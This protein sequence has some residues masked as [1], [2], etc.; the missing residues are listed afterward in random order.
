MNHKIVE[1]ELQEGEIIEITPDMIV[2]DVL[3][4]YPEV[5]EVFREM[6]VNCFSCQ[7]ATRDSI[8]EAAVLHRIDPQKL[9]KKINTTI[10][11]SRK[12]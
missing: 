2:G 4:V 1:I 8:A 6:N 3:E 9:C 11:K 10:K 7:A 12:K 5:A